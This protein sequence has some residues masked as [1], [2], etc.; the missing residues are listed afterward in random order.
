MHERIK[1][2]IQHY[3][4]HNTVYPCHADT[5]LVPILSEGVEKS[6]ETAS[7]ADSGCSAVSASKVRCLHV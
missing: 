5:Q 4:Q 7:N 6:E 1:L 3:Y 2:A